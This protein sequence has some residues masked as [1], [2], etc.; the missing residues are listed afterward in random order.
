VQ[1][2][3]RTTQQDRARTQQD[4]TQ[5]RQDRTQARVDERQQ[6]IRDSRNR[7]VRILNR[8]D[9]DTLV[10]QQQ[11]QAIR[12]NRDQRQ[13]RDRD[14]QLSVQLQQQNR[15]SQ[16]RSYQ[17]YRRRHDNLYL[18]YWNDRHRYYRDDWFFA[19]VVFS[20][21]YN[22][23]YYG[24]N[25]YQSDLIRQAMN[26]GYEEGFHA[27][28]ADRYDHWRFDYRSNYIYRDADYG[29]YGYYVDEDMYSHY[30]REGFR[31][32]YEDGYY[33]RYRYGRYYGGSYSLRRDVLDSVFR[34]EVIGRY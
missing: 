34:I 5:V 6:V 29:Y 8:G 30:F 14:Q 33:G 22:G 31:R 26:Y 21:F 17:D 27:G 15:T 3:R 12:F 19:P 23:G 4:R 9:R 10:R 32:G 7:E 1:Q 18:R 28:R 2:D 25:H 20:L 24:I 16:Y 13:I 11:D